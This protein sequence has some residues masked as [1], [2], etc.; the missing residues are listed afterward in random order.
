[1]IFLDSTVLIDYFNGNSTW[2]VDYLDTIL[3][4]ELVVIGDIVI[5]EVL[6]GFRTDKD[7]QTAKSVLLEFPCYDICDKNLAIK[8]ADNFRSLRKKGII[9]RKTIDMIIATFCIE[10]NLSLLHNDKDFA[11]I[12]E[13]LNLQVVTNTAKR[14]TS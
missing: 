11:L 9:I 12:A 1:M 3:G 13:N 5:A 6:Q 10:N 14:K 8:S 7:Y 2:Q 4:T